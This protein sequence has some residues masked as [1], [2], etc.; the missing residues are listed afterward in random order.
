MRKRTECNGRPSF[1]S[2]V[3]AYGGLQDEVARSKIIS[4]VLLSCCK[5]LSRRCVLQQLCFA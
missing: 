5:V 3:E 4:M 1:H 2:R